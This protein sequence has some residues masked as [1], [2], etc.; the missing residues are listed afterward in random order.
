MMNCQEFLTQL[1][2]Y[3]A[4]ELE[5]RVIDA[6][7]AHVR[8]CPSC[9]Q[10]LTRR[11]EL[12]ARLRSQNVPPPRPVFFAQALVHARQS[13]PTRLS[14]WPRLVGAALAASLAVWIGFGAWSGSQQTPSASDKLAGIVIALHETKTIQLAFNAEQALT[15]AMLHIHLPDG[16]ELRGFPDQREVHWRT[17]LA[18]GVNLLSLPLTAVAASQG[19]LRARLE[20]DA[21][22]TEFTVPLRVH[23]PVTNGAG[24]VYSLKRAVLRSG[25][26]YQIFFG[27]PTKELHHA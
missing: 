27:S 14:L 22:S 23:G 8:A 26:Q 11:H 3:M 18:R 20:H 4:G 1:D 9:Q 5:P 6:A 17:D 16:I 10:R 7:G 13:A 12:R 2:E 19:T 25:M 24:P 15:G 21:R